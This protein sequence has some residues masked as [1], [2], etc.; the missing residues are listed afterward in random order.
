MSKNKV[1]ELERQL[2]EAKT[3]QSN[4]NHTWGEPYEKTFVEKEEYFTGEYREY[5]VHHDPIYNYRDKEVKKWVRECKK[6]GKEHTTKKMKQK[7][8]VTGPD[9]GEG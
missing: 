8:V 3:E 4:C 1:K 6:C 5:G 2:E 9:F 7:V